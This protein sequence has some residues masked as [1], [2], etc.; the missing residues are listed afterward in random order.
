MTSQPETILYATGSAARSSSFVLALMTGNA[1]YL[2]KRLNNVD[3]TFVNLSCTI[4]D[5]QV[6]GSGFR[7]KTIG[8]Y[9]LAATVR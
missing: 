1:D 5:S 7:Y 8:E 4:L 6:V 9:K 2:R 3:F